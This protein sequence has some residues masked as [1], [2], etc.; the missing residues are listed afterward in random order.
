MQKGPLSL[1]MELVRIGGKDGRTTNTC[2]SALEYDCG[3]ALGMA[4]SPENSLNQHNTSVDYNLSP[5]YVQEK[6]R[7]TSEAV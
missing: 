7:P 6:A 1:E 2:R 4:T 5:D 3:N